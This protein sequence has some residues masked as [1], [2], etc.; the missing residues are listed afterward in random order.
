MINTAKSPQ[1]G[2]ALA[3]VEECLAEL[4]LGKAI[5]LIDNES[6]EN[7]GDLVFASQFVTPELINFMAKEARGLICTPITEERAKELNLPPM[8]YDNES[9]HKTAFTIS[10]DSKI[11]T[12][13]GISSSDR[14]KTITNLCLPTAKVDD[15]SRPGHIFPLIAKKFGVLEREGH[16]EASIDLCKLAGLYPCAVICEIM[17]EDGTMSR[18]PELVNLSKKWN[19]KI[20]T[21]HSLKNYIIRN[22]QLLNYISQCTLPTE[23]G[24]LTLSAL[25]NKI[26]HERVLILSNPKINSNQVRIHSSCVTSEIFGSKRCDC[27]EQL[28]TAMEI[29]AKE[30]GHIIYLD[31]EG[32]GIGLEEK[33]KAYG[34]QEKQGLDTVDANIALGHPVDSRVYENAYYALKWLN[35]DEVTLLTNNPSKA[36]SL[37]ELGM[38]VTIKPLKLFINPHNFNYLKSKMEKL[39]HHIKLPQS[40]SNIE[41]RH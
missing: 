37:L 40:A 22:S 3:T 41:S 27:S 32:R 7:E 5:I 31:Q 30:G 28:R 4:K 12:T 39:G 25:S 16:T 26:N 33:I 34:I 6:R 23:F 11:G 19:L 35:L 24:N 20:L 2:F 13:T 18:L 14:S 15:F 17:N 9:D 8:V 38:K 36:T 1:D 29:I 21:I 10:I